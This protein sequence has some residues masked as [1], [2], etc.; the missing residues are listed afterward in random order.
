MNK[1]C[2]LNFSSYDKN[3]IKIFTDKSHICRNN[4]FFQNIYQLKIYKMCNLYS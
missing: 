2:L 3:K 1:Q 4:E